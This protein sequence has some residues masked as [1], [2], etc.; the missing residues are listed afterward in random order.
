MADDLV[1]RVTIT[2]VDW[3]QEFLHA[4]NMGEQLCNSVV[5][6]E[7][8]VIGNLITELEWAIKRAKE[9]LAYIQQASQPP[10]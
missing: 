3:A 9:N 5:G 1:R 4:V 8:E 10:V 7:R 6:A 2:P